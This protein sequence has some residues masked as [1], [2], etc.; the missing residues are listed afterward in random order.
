MPPR[1]R[2][3]FVAFAATALVAAPSFANWP[4]DPTVNVPM[5]TAANDQYDVFSI[6][7]GAG[8][9][10]MVWTDG[11]NLVDQYN[12]YAQRVDGLG[13]V[14]WGAAGVPVCTADSIQAVPS[15]CS[16]GAGGVIVSWTDKRGTSFDIYAQRLNAA[17]APQWATNGVLIA[18]GPGD[19]TYS[20]MISDGS[21]GAIMAWND[22][23]AG[24]GDIYARRVNAAGVP[25][26]TA[27]GVALCTAAGD[28]GGVAIATDGANGAI[29]SWADARA[30]GTNNDIYVRRIN[31]AGVPQWTADGVALCTAAGQQHHNQMIPDGNG[32][33]IVSWYDERLGTGN[34]DIYARRVDASGNAQ[35]TLNGSPVCTQTASQYNPVIASDG[36]G[37]A[38]IAW[39]D[40]RSPNGTYAQHLNSSGAQTWTAGGV[41]VCTV[42]SFLAGAS[43]RILSDGA[44]G[45][46][47]AWNDSRVN[48]ATHIYSQRLSSTG[49]AMWTANGIAICTA[50]GGQEYPSFVMD[51]IGGVIYSWADYRTGNEDIYGQRVD[52]FGTLGFSEPVIDKVR[53]VANDQGGKV[54]VLWEPTSFDTGPS[55]PVESYTLWRRIYTTS[56]AQRARALEQVHDSEPGP[57][58]IRITPDGAQSLYWQ[59]IVTMP[60]RAFP[61]YSYLVTTGSDSLP[62]Q[63]P[64][65]VFMVEAKKGA[66]YYQSRVD[67]GYSVDNLSPTSPAPFTASVVSGTTHLHWNRNGETDLYGYRLYRGATSGFVPSPGNLVSAQSDTGYADA[68]VGY[69]YRLSAVDVHGNESPF[70]LL[71]PQQTTDV[72]PGSG[73]LSLTLTSANPSRREAVLACAIPRAGPVRVAVFDLAGREVREL[74][75]GVRE[76]GEYTVRWDGHT[77]AGGRAGS[78][79]YL[80]RLTTRDGSRGVRCMLLQ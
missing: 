43:P 68:A 13:H 61:G 45:A 7:D 46:V 77:A 30:G 29:V 50:P 26:W 70:A 12:I 31:S 11:R 23:R 14:L 51:A 35:W 1:L 4:N 10:I 20:P 66:T 39:D 49:S 58:S 22:S 75:S 64:W 72:E 24:G 18:G 5:C 44:G 42:V 34:T 32:G 33:A 53:D 9:A 80:I 28:Q 21:G 15:L 73:R 67:S 74:A 62:G 47:I 19:Q 3:C 57:G 65:N 76:A 71:T 60:A 55:N 56:A 16:D 37:G 41:G 48:G 79:L 63:I 36:S 40:Y 27:N 54:E 2:E 8:G 52:G 25:Q 78:G 38:I 59:F 17:G 6:P 69:Y